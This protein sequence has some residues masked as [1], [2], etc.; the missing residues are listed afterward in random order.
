MLLAIVTGSVCAFGA[1]EPGAYSFAIIALWIVWLAMQ[2][3][4]ALRGHRPVFPPRWLLLFFLL[5]LLQITPLPEAFLRSL[6]LTQASAFTPIGDADLPSRW[7]TLSAVPHDTII[8]LYKLAGYGA[9]F[10]IVVWGFSFDTKQRVLLT[11]LIALGCAEASLGLMQYLTGVDHFLWYENSFHPG[12]ATGTYIN[13]NHFAGLLEMTLPLAGGYAYYFTTKRR[14]P[15]ANFKIQKTSDPWRAAFCAFLLVILFLGIAF[16]Q[17]RAGITSSVLT[18]LLMA[19]LCHR[20]QQSGRKGFGFTILFL[21]AFVYIA[22]I[23][24]GPILARFEHLYQEKNFVLAGRLPIWAEGVDLFLAAPLLGSGLGAFA[25]VFQRYQS[26]FPNGIFEHA[27]NDYLEIAAETGAV[28]FAIL[29]IPILALWFIAA[30]RFVKEREPY[31]AAVLLGAWGGMSSI[32]LHSFTDFNL[33]IPANAIVFS[34]LAGICYKACFGADSP[35][36]RPKNS[37]VGPAPPDDDDPEDGVPKRLAT[38]WKKSYSCWIAGTATAIVLFSSVSLV[39]HYQA[40]RQLKHLTKEGLQAAALLDPGSAQIA[41]A[42]G[43]YHRNAISQDL[44]AALSYL[45]QAVRNSRQDPNMWLSLGLAQE[46]NGQ[47]HLAGESVSRAVSLGPHLPRIAWPAA[48]FYLRQG[49]SEQAFRLFRVSLEGNA[50]L[51]EAIFV[52]CWNLSADGDRILR[53][54]IPA[55]ASVELQYL[56]F[57]VIRNRFPEAGAVWNRLLQSTDAFAPERAGPYLHRLIVTGRVQAAQQAWKALLVRSGLSGS[58]HSGEDNLISNG[59]FEGQLVNFGFDWRTN[60]P[61]GVRAGLDSVTYRSPGHAFLIEFRGSEN[62]DFRSF[63]QYVPVEPGRTYRFEGF[64]RTEGITTDSGPRFEVAD[65][66]DPRRL[67]KLGED[68]LGTQGWTR[69]EIIF[70]AGQDTE[71]V[72]VGV[73]RLRSRKLDNQVAGSAWVDDLRLVPYDPAAS[74]SRWE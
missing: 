21:L 10:L 61:P 53:E 71:L 39:R 63:Y 57:L 13:R 40:E 49:N 6:S 65:A 5:G 1:V 8:A 37:I 25:T 60:M 33:Q 58:M 17:S 73:S 62:L 69:E 72:R 3:H 29:F 32:L 2:W 47:F 55:N 22:W 11:G 51:A 19:F 14:A 67:R 23:G 46:A 4:D 9:A 27:H 24:V 35:A 52:T 34:I 26:N 48:N 70:T 56:N 36:K 30:R 68:L 54:A 42:A 50:S 64:L 7:I 38:R 74:E 66:F 18:L 28:G 45:R 16:S 15:A 20:K 44:P 59:R 41:H 31:R 12:V 43:V